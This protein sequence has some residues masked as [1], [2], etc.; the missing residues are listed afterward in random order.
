MWPFSRR[1]PMTEQE[2]VRIAIA[3]LRKKRTSV[4]DS[5]PAQ[6]VFKPADEWRPYDRWLVYFDTHPGGCPPFT[7]IEIKMPS[8]K[9]VAVPM[10]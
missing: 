7:V 1:Q 5:T 2:A 10:I 4:T 9:P 3:F 8:R 6:A